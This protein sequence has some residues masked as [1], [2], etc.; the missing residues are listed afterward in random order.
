MTTVST[1][2]TC[3]HCGD[4]C[5]EEIPFDNH[6][7]C[8][9]GCC[10]VYELLSSNNLCDYYSLETSPGIS[11]RNPVGT[12]RFNYLD[13]I[14]VQHKL[15]DYKDEN[16]TK[17]TFFVPTMHCSSCIWLLENLYKIEK[18]IHRSQVNFLKKTVS[19]TYSSQSYSLRKLVELLTSVGY[20]PAIN[21][22]DIETQVKKEVNRRLSYQIGVAGFCFGNIMLIS[23]P[24]YFGLDEFTRSTFSRLFGYLNFALS[25]P[26]FL[27]SA[28]DYFKNAFNGLRKRHIPIDVPLALGI[29][30]LFFRS[31][32]EVFSHTGIGYFDTHAGLVFFLLIGKWFQQKTFDTLSFE[33]DYKSYF[34]VAVSKINDGLESTVPVNALKIGDRILIRNQELIPADAILLNG[35]AHIDFSFVTGESAPVEKVLGEIIYAGGRQTGPTIELEVCKKVSQSYLTQL[36]NNENFSKDQESKVETFQLTVSKYFTIILLVIA[37]GSAAYWLLV[38]PE[39][40]MSAF[41]AVLIIACPCALALSSPFALGT[42]MRVLGNNKCYLKSAGVVE[43]LAKTDTIVFDKTGTITQPGE[44]E[45]AYEG[46][47]LSQDD[48]NKIYTMVS[49]SMHPLSLQIK[50]FLTEG[51]KVSMQDFHEIPGNGMEARFADTTVKVGSQSFVFGQV[52]IQENKGMNQSTQVYISIDKEAKG[53]FTFVQVYRDGLKDVVS[54][55]QRNYAICLLSGDNQKEKNTLQNIFGT[56]TPLLFKQSPMEKLTYI[57]NLQESNKKV[58]MIG[59]GLNDAGALKAA[60]IGISVTENTASFSPASDIIMDASKFNHLPAFLQFSKNT[61]TVIHIS[62]IISLIYNVIGL[63]FAVQGILSPLIAAI[64]MPVSS[65][66][67]IVFTTICTKVYAKL[68]GLQ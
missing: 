48:A 26:V 54:E 64:L 32:Y 27:F 10:N 58:L 12:H 55:M 6:V 16:I 19:V 41:T 45:I 44:S 52:E 40:A 4:I 33:R 59:D 5:S 34:P 23:F 20:E 25:I 60:N 66:S 57:Q 24:E 39:L 50:K 21:L 42:A 68:R 63:S 28:A 13:D 9:T 17:V 49:S 18:N 62:F 1:Q 51:L 67:V 31:M 53:Y 22:N 61:L 37:F 65:V 3:Y 56:Q 47:P 7:F 35:E 36:W 8:C 15:L 46:L 43:Q 38:K 11:R 2:S 29:F 14:Q 30:V